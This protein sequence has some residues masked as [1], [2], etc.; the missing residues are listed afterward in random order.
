MPE[1]EGRKPSSRTQA[2]SWSYPRHRDFEGS[3]R[4][5]AAL[6]FAERGHKVSARYSYLLADWNDWPSNIICPEVVAMI[7]SERQRRE[8]RQEGFPLHKYIHHGLSSQA[9]VFNLIGPLMARNDVAALRSAFVEQGLP[10]PEGTA[11]ADFEFEDR[12]VFREDTGQPTSIDVVIRDAAGLPVLFVE[13]K[14][15][16][17]EFGG[18]SVFKN[19]DCDGRNPARELTDCYLHHLG[20]RYWELLGKWG[21]LNGTASTDS[22][23]LLVNHYQFFR[24]VLFALESGGTFVLLSDDRSPTFFCRGPRGDRGLMPL[25]LSLVPDHLLRH[26][27]HVSVQ[28]VVRSIKA[29]GRHTWI[30]DFER[31]YGLG[32]GY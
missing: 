14:F 19:G 29:T 10:W 6:W 18:C 16:E 24:E 5:A 27:G 4:R 11:T 8:A 31:K 28:S 26:I 32:A 7:Q 30:A 1:D 23:C 3:I 13:S 2:R 9:M 12:G 21:F 20:R 15:V 25:L 17:K 22:T